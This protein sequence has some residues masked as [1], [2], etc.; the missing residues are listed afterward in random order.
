M[1]P[2]L[3]LLQGTGLSGQPV[4][5]PRDLP[6]IPTVLI[7]SFQE[8]S[9]VDAKAWKRALDAAG[10]PWMSLPTLPEDVAQ[11]EA[12]DEVP[13][14]MAD[15]GL[16]TRTVMIH[17]GGPALLATFG[18]TADLS[19]KVLLVL[20]DATVLYAHGGPFSDEAAAALMDAI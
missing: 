19:A 10:V 9:R 15:E 6:P 5:F 16:W 3:P 14:P 17:T 18:W 1:N 11:I 8:D 13:G 4:A 20:D 7:I 2:R 12:L